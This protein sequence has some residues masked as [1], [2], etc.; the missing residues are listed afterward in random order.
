MTI[1][2]ILLAVI[3]TGILKAKFALETS[4]PCNYT[5]DAFK[6]IL[7]AFDVVRIGM[8]DTTHTATTSGK[9]QPI[10]YRGRFAL[11]SGLAPRPSLSQ[12]CTLALYE[13]FDIYSHKL[14]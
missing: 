4:H 13:H 11:S 1:I 9:A 12:F 5:L 2:I 14:Y 10:N 3:T 8:A 6:R 7:G